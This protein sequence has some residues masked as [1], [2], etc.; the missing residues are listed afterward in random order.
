MRRVSK[1]AILSNM[2]L[3][4]FS[5]YI[6]FA[7]PFFLPFQTVLLLREPMIDGEKWQYGTIGVYFSDIILALALSSLVFSKWKSAWRNQESRIKNQTE[8]ERSLIPYSLFLILFIGW[9]GL[10]ILWAPD[11]VL[12]GYFFMKLL[13]GAS[14]F[15]LAQSLDA[16]DVK[17]ALKVLLAAAVIQGVIGIG[18]FISQETVSSSLLGMSAHESWT[19][20]TSVLKSEGGRFL[21][22]YG[23]LP[24]PNVLGGFLAIILVIAIAD[25]RFQIADLKKKD[26]SAFC[27]LHSVFLILILLALILTFSR[28]AWLGVAIGIVAYYVFCILYPSHQ[29]KSKCIIIPRPWNYDTFFKTMFVLGIATVVFVF[30]LRDQVFPRFDVATIV[31]EGSVS[32]RMVSLEDARALIVANPIAGVGA[33]NFT[34]AIMK[35]E[36]ARPVWNVQPAHNVFALVWAE[37]GVVG[38]VL[39]LFFIGSVVHGVIPSLSR[40]PGILRY[41]QN[42]KQGSEMPQNQ[43]VIFAV[44]FLMLLPSLLLD[45]WLWSSHFGILFFF[46][47][48]G[49]VARK[50]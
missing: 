27:I 33:G 22:A 4:K 3:P 11:Q 34:K 42:D 15:F 44:A 13:L 24:H 2:S 48:V 45:H 38:V 21:R 10:S 14:V 25:F 23:S 32:E 39:L 37:L 12:A 29:T 19:A 18:Q 16:S 43:K 35:N 26:N 40:N 7:F 20:G 47:L 49:F 36:P 1:S 46:L 41:A 17:T 50:P 8:E 5:K 6:F 31:G 28:S 30:V 9:S